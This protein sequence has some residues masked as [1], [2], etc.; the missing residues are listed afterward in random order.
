MCG[1]VCNRSTQLFPLLASGQVR[2]VDNFE[3]WCK[4]VL[5][6]SVVKCMAEEQKRLTM[7][8]TTTRTEDGVIGGFDG[9]QGSVDLGLPKVRLGTIHSPL[10]RA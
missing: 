8:C 2:V 9:Y 1:Y 7:E 3:P 4:S 10:F 5:E 6:F